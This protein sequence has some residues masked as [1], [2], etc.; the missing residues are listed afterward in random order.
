MKEHAL[1]P[2]MP[3]SQPPELGLLLQIR[4]LKDEIQ[5]ALKPELLTKLA[6]R[7]RRTPRAAPSTAAPTAAPAAAPAA[8]GQPSTK[9]APSAAAR[10]APHPLHRQA[11]KAST[12]AAQ[13]QPTDART[14]AAGPADLPALVR[15][16]FA[17]DGLP[18][19]WL[20]DAE[21]AAGTAAAD[22][23]MR[24][25]LRRDEGSAAVGYTI[26]EAVLLLSSSHTHL[27]RAGAQPLC[28]LPSLPANSHPPCCSQPTVAGGTAPPCGPTWPGTD[29]VEV[30]CAA[31]CPASPSA[32]HSEHVWS[33]RHVAR[34]T[35][36][37]N[38]TTSLRHAA[39]KTLAAVAW[40]AR[41]RLAGLWAPPA[42]AAAAALQHA[43][44]FAPAVPTGVPQPPAVPW[45]QVWAHL[46]HESVVAAPVL[47]LLQRASTVD[48]SVRAEALACLCALLSVPWELRLLADFSWGRPFTGAPAAVLLPSPRHCCHARDC[49]RDGARLSP[50]PVQVRL[51]H[52]TVLLAPSNT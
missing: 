30:A 18:V 7:P 29:V 23:A 37:G 49:G 26:E 52:C 10:P 32:L 39:L 20:T 41:P 25:P 45:R 3:A 43:D 48:A 19:G 27:Q 16:R 11:A 14:P 12:A 47:Q 33:H 17:T 35:A 42:G 13:P 24:D 6:A 9:P 5:T 40:R 31:V 22:V 44:S 28:I 34:V 50:Q 4:H 2:C 21:V 15:T 8:P 1:G 38:C 46:Q 51:G 36:H